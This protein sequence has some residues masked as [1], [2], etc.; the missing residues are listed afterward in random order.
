MV[1]DKGNFS[2]NTDDPVLTG[3]NL[4]HEYHFI[5]EK[6]GITAEDIKTAVSHFE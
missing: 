5:M 6:Y 2:I 3:S 4:T 1:A